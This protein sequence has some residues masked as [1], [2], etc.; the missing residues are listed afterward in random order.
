MQTNDNAKKAK[1]SVTHRRA[2]QHIRTAVIGRRLK[3]LQSQ[4]QSQPQQTPAA[5]LL[6]F[7]R[8]CCCNLYTN[9]LRKTERAPTHARYNGRR[10]PNAHSNFYDVRFRAFRCVAC[11][12]FWFIVAVSCWRNGNDQN[13]SENSIVKLCASGDDKPSHCS[14]A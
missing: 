5:A 3:Q 6:L 12:S 8:F 11:R 7:H 1:K 13:D 14:S 10:Q 9:L 2:H 4:S